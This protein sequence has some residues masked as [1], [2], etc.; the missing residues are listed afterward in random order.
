MSGPRFKIDLVTYDDP[1]A[2]LPLPV[3][4]EPSRA[5]L[6]QHGSAALDAS[7]AHN[8]QLLEQ[9][10]AVLI[11]TDIG[12]VH[13]ISA[14]DVATTL[15]PSSVLAQR[16]V[17]YNPALFQYGMLDVETAADTP[18][19]A[20]AAVAAHNSQPEPKT[21][22]STRKH[23]NSEPAPVATERK[24]ARRG[25]KQDLYVLSSDEVQAAAGKLSAY[26][27][28]TLASAAD[29]AGAQSD[30][31]DDSADDEEHEEQP[32][33]A[34]AGK[35]RGG[36]QRRP[37]YRFRLEGLRGLHQELL[38][39]QAQG[40]LRLVPIEQL[41]TLLAAL[42]DVAGTGRNRLLAEDADVKS[43][44]VTRVSTALEAVL[45]ELVVLTTPRLPPTLYLE[46]QLGRIVELAKY[47][48][49]YNVLALHETRFKRIYR[50]GTADEAKS[51]HSSF[52]V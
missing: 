20:G 13:P 18:V 34:A 10:N 48:L 44:R 49:Q 3:A 5:A 32:A 35:Q 19:R 6:L 33:A 9:L 28:S 7:M 30:V 45:C 50:P 46:E 29:G 39:A 51:G 16:L 21:N 11:G 27:A 8:A 24:R 4:P 22:P 26:L 42:D 25:H 31:E 2:L 15:N 38:T 40:Y 47:H 52:T 41:A 12:Y 23:R 14:D 43:P 37:R 1:A 17:A 36:A